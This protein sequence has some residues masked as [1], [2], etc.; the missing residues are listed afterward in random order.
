VR[1]D[2]ENY[3]LFLRKL[4]KANTLLLGNVLGSNAVCT[5]CTNSEYTPSPTLAWHY[6]LGHWV[7]NEPGTGD[8]AFSSPGIYG[9][10]PWIDSARVYYGILARSDIGTGTA[11]TESAACGRLIRKA[12]QY[13]VQY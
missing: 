2:A 5:V 1:I 13:G 7:E 3:G 6:S 12:W 9:F 11:A 8:G 10:Y 4:L